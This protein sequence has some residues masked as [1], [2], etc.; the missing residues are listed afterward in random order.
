[1]NRDFQL[2][3]ADLTKRMMEGDEKAFIALYERYAGPLYNFAY[4]KLSDKQEAEDVVHDVF[5]SLW[6]RRGGIRFTSTLSAYLFSAVR[7]KAFDVFAH[8]SVKDKHLKSLQ[9][10]LEL[11]SAGSPADFRIRRL[12]M[13]ELI[14]QEIQAL[15]SRMREI[16]MLSRH[17]QL[18][19]LEIAEQLDISKHTVDTQIK[20]A[21]R[22]LRTRLGPITT[23]YLLCSL[24]IW[25]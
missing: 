20:R 5:M 13:D 4:Q 24:F 21:L 15:P 16:F 6:H 19:H 18:S 7:N 12:Q 3:D 11:S 25:M 10:F 14:Q 1:M 17:D 9:E 2:S 22:I 8:R 23:V